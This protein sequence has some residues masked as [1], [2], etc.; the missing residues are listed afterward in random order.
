MPKIMRGQN[1]G[2]YVYPCAKVMTLF[3]RTWISM[4]YSYKVLYIDLL[5]SEFGLYQT[6]NGEDNARKACMGVLIS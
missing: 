5:L 2:A 6:L 4:S 1:R 3:F